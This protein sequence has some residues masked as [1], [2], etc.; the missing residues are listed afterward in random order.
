MGFTDPISRKYTNA[1]FPSRGPDRVCFLIAVERAY[2]CTLGFVHNPPLSS[3]EWG[4]AAAA[5]AKRARTDWGCPPHL[6]HRL[7]VRVR[8]DLLEIR[9]VAFEHTCGDHGRCVARAR[10]TRREP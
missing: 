8:E 6:G 5:P 1:P 9:G 3:P 4:R 10:R 7:R 2:R